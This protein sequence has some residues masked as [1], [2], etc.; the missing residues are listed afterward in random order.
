MEQKLTIAK[1]V[2]QDPEKLIQIANEIKNAYGTFLIGC[3]TAGKVCLT[4]SYL[5]AQIAKRHVNV[6]FSSE[7]PFFK[8]FLKEKS[9]VIAVSQSGETAD[10][11]EALEVA[12]SKGSKVL[13]IINVENSSIDR[14]A[15][16]SL[17]LKVG[18][19]KAVASTKATTAQLAL[20]TLLAYTCAGDL[21]EGQKLLINATSQI[22]DMLNPRYEDHIFNLAKK[23]HHFESMY[24]IGRSANYPIALEA[25]IK[26]QEVSYIHAEGFAGGELKH[27]PLALI[28]DG[29]PTI[30]L[31]ANDGALTET[32][33]NA[34]E[35]K[36][37][38]GFI[39]GIGPENHEVFDY[40]IKVPDV[41]VISPLVNI[42]PIQILA[43]QL[44]VIRQNDPDMPR[45]LA[46]SVTVK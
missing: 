12:K 6:N 45:N 25:A 8:D 18:P 2:N 29:T 31:T 15:D 43:Y 38:G 46:K 26:L 33:S 32:I 14:I 27:G 16:F 22:N 7:F 17:H 1:A 35:I 36:S 41:G 13:A 20:L 37:R 34:I 30:V 5:F 10:T 28:T 9:L 11:L 4:A 3:G 21:E 44:G 19:E 40:W 23:I 39:I 42:I 24:V